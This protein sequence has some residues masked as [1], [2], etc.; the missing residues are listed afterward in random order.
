MP[1]VPP[2]WDLL[3]LYHHFARNI[4]KWL[5][6]VWQQVRHSDTPY[7]GLWAQKALACGLHMIDEAGWEP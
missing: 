5:T 4:Q 3:G 1:I 6:P 2:T 7:R